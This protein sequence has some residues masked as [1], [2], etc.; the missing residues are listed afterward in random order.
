MKAEDEV[1]RLRKENARLAAALAASVAKVVEL[2]REKNAAFN[3]FVLLGGK[4]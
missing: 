4:P 2:E 3:A 1:T